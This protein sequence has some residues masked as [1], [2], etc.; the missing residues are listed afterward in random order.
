MR[1][2]DRIEA[3]RKLALKLLKYKNEAVV[4]YALPRGGVVLGYEIA[5]ELGAP[6]DLVITRKIGHP[7]MPEYAVCVTA[8]DGDII[9]SETERTALNPEWLK[10]EIEKERKEAKRRRETYLKGRKPYSLE[11]KTAIVVD[12]G[13]ATGLTFLLAIKELKHLNPKKIIA[14]VP[15]APKDTAEKI[16]KEA[17]EFV[18]LY[19]PVYYLGAV[20]AY[21]DDFLQVKDEEVIE[22]L[23]KSAK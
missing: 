3:G 5:K 13:I 14:A 23:E 22:L 10:R 1:F 21:Y 12:D 15:V 17:D 19:I 16:K 6:L 8:E 2:K 18:T 7:H 20:G 11:N 9:C 4:V